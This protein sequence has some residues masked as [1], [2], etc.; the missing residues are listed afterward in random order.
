MLW[1][2]TYIGLI[3]YLGNFISILTVFSGTALHIYSTILSLSWGPFLNTASNYEDGVILEKFKGKG[4]SLAAVANF[5]ITI[6]ML[7]ESFM[8]IVGIIGLFFPPAVPV[9]NVINGI[10]NALIQG[11]VLFQ[12]LLD[13]F[14]F[15]NFTTWGLN[16][17]QVH[18]IMYF[19][20]L[21]RNY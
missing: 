16:E 8:Q 1:C 10:F 2:S 11:G 14:I 17:K 21:P 4:S 7:F 3:P 6:P 15:P 18:D 12:Q 9:I 13:R 19:T 20:I 5:A